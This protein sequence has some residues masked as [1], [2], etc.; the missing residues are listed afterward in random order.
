MKILTTVLVLVAAT[1]LIAAPTLQVTISKTSDP[2]HGYIATVQTGSVGEYGVGD[3]FRTFCLERRESTGT[4]LFD[5]Y[6]ND[7][8]VLGGV[9]GYDPLDYRTAFLYTEF[10][11]G[12]LAAAVG[13]DYNDYASFE[14]LQDVVWAI[15][16]EGAVSWGTMEQDLLDYANAQS[17]SSIG[18][19]RVLNLFDQAGNY[20]QDFLVKVPT[21]GAVVLG[22][23]GVALV[24]WVRRR[25][26]QQ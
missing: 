8:A 4:D 25:K 10:C 14:A 6:V 13:Y 24:G 5:A 11:N 1:S 16:G 12:N 17:L 20:R 23:I 2:A 9:G 19:V 22:S 7:G 3:S 15:E 26:V 21:P 18:N